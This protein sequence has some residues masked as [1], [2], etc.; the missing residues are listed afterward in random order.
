MA[1][2]ANIRVYRYAA[3]QRF[4]KHVDE[5]V[6][7]EH[8]NISQWTVLIYLNGGPGALSGG[9]RGSGGSGAEAE[10][11]EETLRGGETVFYKVK[12]SISLESATTCVDSMAI[13]RVRLQPKIPF[14]SSTSWVTCTN[15]E[16]GVAVAEARASSQIYRGAC[17]SREPAGYYFYSNYPLALG[18]RWPEEKAPSRKNCQF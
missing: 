13:P 1:C 18:G 3:G 6:E 7:D 16:I 10:M 5:S 15:R 11:G 4:G 17:M 12:E 2:N 14:P 8:G 9:D